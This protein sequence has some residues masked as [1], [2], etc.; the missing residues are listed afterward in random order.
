LTKIELLAPAKDLECGRV[1]IDCGADAVYIGPAKY[2]AREAAGNSLEDIAALCAYAH[3]YWARV[4]ATVNTLVKDHELDHAVRLVQDLYY[5]AGVDGVIIQ[6][7]ALLECDLPPVPL[8]ASTQMHNHTP[9]RVAFLHGVGMKRAILARELSLE[10]IREIHA[11]APEMELEAFVHG[12]LCVC[13]SGQCNLSFALGGRSGNRGAC[14]QP[15]RKEYRLVDGEGRV[16]ENGK[17]LLSIKDLNLSGHLGVL[18]EAGVSSFKIEG[19]L[20]DATYVAN[21]TAYYRAKLDEVIAASPE[22]K[23]SSSGALKVEFTPDPAKTFNRGFTTHFLGGR[24]PAKEPIGAPETPKMLGEPLG[25]V[26]SVSRQGVTLETDAQLHPGD[27]L[28]FFDRA[29]RLTGSV[30]NAV[31]GRTFLPRML[32]SF[33]VGALI[34][35]NHDHEFL[36]AVKKSRNERKIGV[37]LR[38]MEVPGGLALE[39]ADEDGIWAESTLDC[40]P[41]A[42]EKPEAATENLKRQLAKTG[43]TDFECRGVELELEKPIFLPVSEINA[44]RRGALE[45]L[46]EEREKARPRAEGGARINTLPYPEKELTYNGNVLNKK[47]A[48]F[49]RRHGVEQIEPAAE[50]GLRMKGRK[51]M[52]TRYCLRHQMG[53][54]ARQPE[55]RHIAEPWTLIDC[56]GNRLR[57]NFCCDRCE[58]EVYL[59]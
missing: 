16:I 28:C 9:E 20:K 38:L 42:A 43:G 11:A 31:Q 23:R 2:G 53:M 1:A 6:D 21:V 19:R 5:K 34:Y 54:C 22:L 33:E 29:G 41:A 50:S 25:R 18:I 27:G 10:Q 35:R 51:V 8:I 49:Y 17:H 32:E 26:E 3:K 12:A 14:A 58:M 13:Y 37:T 55:T 36:N 24:G 15:C 40:A 46:A 7:A 56:E 48:A 59:E 52:T 44:L 30:V 57:L 4:Y 39:A 47:A 45:A